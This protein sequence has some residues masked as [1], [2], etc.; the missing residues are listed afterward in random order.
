M[1]ETQIAKVYEPKNVEERWYTYWMDR[2]YF[3]AEVNPDKKP[4]SIVIPPPNV[5][6]MLH[7][8]H[9]Y[10]NTIQDIFIRYH[11]MAGY[12]AMW[13]PGTDHAGIATQNVVERNLKKEENI[14]RHDLGREE[15]VNRVWQWK[16]KFG[17]VIIEQL[18]KLGCSC[19]WDRERFTMDDDLSKT[20]IEVFCRL[21][22]NGLIYR[23]KYIINWCP[24]CSTAL[25]DEEA[26][27]K[28]ENGKLWYI[29][30]PIKG[31]SK[32]ITVATTRPETML[33]DTAVA[34]NPNDNRFKKLIGKTVI[35]PV[36]NREIPIVA[37]HMVDSKF[38]TGAVKVTPAH[39]PND[40]ETGQRH[41]LEQINV[42]N[43]DGTMNENAGKYKGYERFK[44]REALVSEL[45]KL[46]L[47]EKIEKHEHAVAHCQR[48]NTVVEPYLS[49]QWFV[50]VKP[51]AE[52]ALKAVLDADIQFHP[53]KWVKVYANWM[54]NVRDWCISRQLWW[55]HRIPVYYCRDCDHFMVRRSAPEKCEKCNSTNIYQDEDVLDTWFSSW[56]WPFSTMGWPEETPELKYFYPTSTLVTAPDIIFFWVARMVMSGLEFKN[57][58]PFRHVF[59]NGLIRDSQ[60]RK[61]SKSLGN[62]IDPL[63]MVDMY[64]ADAVRFSLLMLTSEGQD[65]NLSETS[66]EI[67]RNFSNK[68]WNSFRFL[69]L[70]FEEDN[71]SDFIRNNNFLGKKE[72]LLLSD[73]W[74]LSRLHKTIDTVTESLNEFHLNDAIN[75]LYSFFW[76]E[77]CDWYLELIKPRLYGEN[78]EARKIALSVAI[79]VMRNIIKLLH[80]TIPFIT[81]EIW[82]QI[83]LD[84]ESDL[85]ISEWPQADP[86]YFDD[87]SET[88]MLLV[89]QVIGSIRNI[90]GEMNVPPNKKAHVLIKSSNSSILNLMQDNEESLTALAKL[91]L[92]E[93]G[94]G[95][96]KPKLSASSVVADMEIFMPLEGLIDIEVERKRLTKEINRLEKQIESINAKLLNKDFINKA[97]KEVI[98]KE[99]QKST[100]FQAN[101]NKFKANLQSFED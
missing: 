17:N 75:S 23:G 5:T 74:I 14:T 81:E 82:Q 39:D 98:E 36:L 7:M 52:P 27:H 48:C 9:A 46:G 32:F 80:P 100:D 20:V 60:G 33:G 71:V 97:P 88:E 72:D 89:Q 50:K 56:L 34:V 19:D 93:L 84:E 90:R 16:E 55:G 40:F 21:Y 79:Y 64:S 61:M 37:D 73:R 11:R 66:F 77:F 51:L 10:N 59:F 83:K 31:S 58:I 30:Y 62:G 45:K 101:L 78:A 67:G 12:E 63:K 68:L 91:E 38:G 99:R 42:M 69:A 54:E 70:S 95:L 65:I 8:G 2:N 24:R 49:T 6:D 47:L 41:Q 57:E 13:L 86:A 92:V 28:D 94:N 1:S 29:K 3:H 53:D 85:I 18:K 87:A 43:E 15:F 26:I 44:C 4:Y 25:S 76:R 96:E 22:E 35:L